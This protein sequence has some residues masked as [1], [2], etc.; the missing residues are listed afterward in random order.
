VE[1]LRH[2]SRTRG[3]LPPSGQGG[4]GSV[5]RATAGPAAGVETRVRVLA[6]LGQKAY[7]VRLVDRPV[8][9]VVQSERALVVG[10]TIEVAVVQPERPP[11]LLAMVDAAVDRGSAAAARAAARTAGVPFEAFVDGATRSTSVGGAGVPP[12]PTTQIATGAVDVVRSLLVQGAAVPADAVQR[13]TRGATVSLAGTQLAVGV[14]GASAPPGGVYVVARAARPAVVEPLGEVQTTEHGPPRWLGPLLHRLVPS[15]GRAPDAGEQLV[16]LARL[17][18]ARGAIA[19][20]HDPASKEVLHRIQQ[21]LAPPTGGHDLARRLATGGTRF[22][23]RARELAAGN[24][25]ALGDDLRTA[26]ASLAELNL[27]KSVREVLVR[28]LEHLTTHALLVA[29]RA[30][31]GEAPWYPFPLSDGDGAA[32]A[33]MR[34]RRGAPGAN[35][36]A[37]G[38]LRAEIAVEFSGTGPVHVDAALTKERVAV[39]IAVAREDVLER[40]RAATAE[41]S[42]RLSTTGRAVLFG[43]SLEPAEALRVDAD[44]PPEAGPRGWVDAVG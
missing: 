43:A 14:D 20:G 3:E 33:W 35:G 25:A 23:L 13:T 38:L 2:V 11:V 30:E 7:A 37:S 26:L 34:W 1:P 44:R 10:G 40:V 4:S 21:Q 39:R 22:E 16:R 24:G 41:L 27:P 8:A 32:T 6:D 29:A 42:E 18:R 19:G 9:L 12:G 31:A 28:A 5:E 17:L 15:D 36:E